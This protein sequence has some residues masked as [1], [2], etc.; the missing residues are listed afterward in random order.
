VEHLDD[1]F[2]PNDLVP[3]VTTEPAPAAPNLDWIDPAPVLQHPED[4]AWFLQSQD[5]FC[6]PASCAMIYN[7]ATGQSLPE[8]E[9]IAV[10]QNA[11]LLRWEGDHWSGMTAQE[12]A[13][14]L[15][16]LG[17]HAEVAQGATI[18][19]LD[20]WVDVEGRSVIL[21]VDSD[22]VWN[23]ADDDLDPN[24]GGADHALRLVEV[25]TERGVAVLE[26]PG[27]PDGRGYELSLDMLADAMDDSGGQVVVTSPTGTPAPEVTTPAATPAVD[28]SLPTTT[29]TDTLPTLDDDFGLDDVP[30]A[31]AAV[32]AAGIGAIILVRVA[33]DNRN[34]LRPR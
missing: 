13:Q 8:S 31:P 15:N 18:Q 23:K 21:A 3:D 19:D 2:D 6:M 4:A 5:G 1:Y 24:D 26:D 27:N 33:L 16:L 28:L 22:E 17:V 10:A 12:G 29:T 25:D 20:K 11:G 14:F 7:E 32:T 9:F 30:L 34:A